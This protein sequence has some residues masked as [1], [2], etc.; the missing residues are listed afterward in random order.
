MPAGV[1]GYREESIN[2]LTESQRPGLCWAKVLWLGTQTG[3]RPWQNVLSGETEKKQTN[4]VIS[5]V[6]AGGGQGYTENK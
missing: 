4:L 6:I 1:R 3:S 2:T 5:M